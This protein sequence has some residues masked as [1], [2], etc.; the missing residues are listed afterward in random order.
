MPKI[1]MNT[2]PQHI[3]LTSDFYPLNVEVS[4]R[5]ATFFSLWYGWNQQP[6]VLCLTTHVN[7]YSNPSWVKSKTEKMA[8]VASL[9]SVHHLRPRAGWPS[10]SLRG[11]GGVSCVSV[12]WVIQ[13]AGSSKYGLNLDQLQ[14][15]WQPLSYIAINCW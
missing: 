12:A 10:V 11:L 8:P 14:Q 13:C 7:V 4:S 5:E 3:I 6:F 9:V 15:I 2:S 1:S